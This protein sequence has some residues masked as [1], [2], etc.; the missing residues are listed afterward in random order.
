M[1][2]RELELKDI[3]GNFPFGL[4]VEWQNIF[5]EKHVSPILQ[6]NIGARIVV[7]E[8]NTTQHWINIE[9]CKPLFNPM[10]AITQPM[11]IEGYN[12]GKEFVPM[13]ELA[14]IECIDDGSNR[15]FERAVIY[16]PNVV[17]I[18]YTEDDCNGCGWRTYEF[19]D[20]GRYSLNEIQLLNQWHFDVNDLIG[21]GLAID[22]TTYRK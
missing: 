21:Q 22:K 2:N 10:S 7:E 14:K 8:F 20:D 11:I 6:S 9:D 12:D 15:A 18:Y 5:K 3:C 4:Q 13:I 17:R 16:A 19:P 1:K